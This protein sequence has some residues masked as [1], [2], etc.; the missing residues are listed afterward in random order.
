MRVS[1][2]LSAAVLTLSFGACAENPKPPDSMGELL[3]YEKI[4]DRCCAMRLRLRYTNELPRNAYIECRFE[5][6]TTEGDSYPRWVT[7]PDPIPRGRSMTF[8]ATAGIGLVEYVEDLELT[9]CK[10]PPD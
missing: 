4:P 8:S 3:S 10:E 6:E 5:V 9:S 7:S 2:V 1:F